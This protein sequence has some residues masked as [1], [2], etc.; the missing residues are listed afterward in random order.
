MIVGIGVD[1]VAIARIERM[2]QQG[3]ERFARRILTDAELAYCLS[4]HRPAESIAARFCVKEAVLKCLG[5]GWAHGLGFQQIDVQ[6]D[7]AG[8]L[9]VALSGAAADRG[10]QLGVRRVHA[11]VTHT[12]STATAF[13]VAEA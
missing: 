5:T 10:R 4:R 11:S 13:V 2:W 1:S 12:E 9:H 6:R 8:A 3:G 7:A